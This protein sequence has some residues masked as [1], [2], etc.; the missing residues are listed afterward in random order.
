MENID[1]KPV[2]DEAVELLR[3]LIRFDTTNPP[4]NELP[5]IE[6]VADVLSDDGIQTS[7]LK[8]APDRANAVGRLKGTGELPPLL[9]LSHVDVVPVEPDEWTYPPFSA[10][11]ADGYIWGR[12]AIDSKLTTAV[13]MMILLLLSRHKVPLKRDVIIAACADE[14]MGGAYGANWLVD[15]HY[16]LIESEYC[17]NEGGGFAILVGGKHFYL[18]QTAE[19]GAYNVDLIAKGQPGHSSTPHDDNSIYR[20][21]RTIERISEEKMPHRVTDSVRKFF[22]GIA[23]AQDDE[24]SKKLYLDMLDPQKEPEILEKLPVDA[25][26]AWMFDAMLRNTCAPTMLEGGVKRNV[27]PSEVKVKLSGRTLPDVDA[28]GFIEEMKKIVGDDVDISAE[29]FARGLEAG[30][31]TPLFGYVQEAIAKHHPEAFVIPY[32]ATGGTDAR[33]FVGTKTKVYGF[34]PMKYEPGPTFFQLCHGH[35]ERISADNVL[36]GVQVLFDVVR[37]LNGLDICNENKQ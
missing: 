34:L 8:S 15:N 14:E 2:K 24:D 36:F 13:E 10:T 23:N 32:M 5:A 29:G 30:H 18:C 1:W 16:D 33:P 3:Q 28:E 26:T 4:G 22:E 37:R 12:G 7:V 19:K 17:I 27:I 9:L 20:L 11:L 25:P 6:F 35:D 31:D 21:A